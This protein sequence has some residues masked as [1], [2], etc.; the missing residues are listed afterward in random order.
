MKE[1]YYVDDDRILQFCV[2]VTNQSEIMTRERTCG[3]GDEITTIGKYIKINDSYSL[4][5]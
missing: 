1:T 3:K 2:C 4:C 5:P